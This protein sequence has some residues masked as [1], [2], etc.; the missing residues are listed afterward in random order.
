MGGA[1]LQMVTGNGLTGQPAN[2]V[3]N[4]VIQEKFMRMRPQLDI[5]DFVFGFVFDPHVNRILSKHIS[6]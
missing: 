4:I 5:V 2:R 1:L 3:L 6:L